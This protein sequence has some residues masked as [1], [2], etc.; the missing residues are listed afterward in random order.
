VSTAV[1][2]NL[3][4]G[5]LGA[6]KTTLIRRLLAASPADERWAVLV[7]EMGQV[8]ID[9]ALFSGSGGTVRELPGGCL[10]CTLGVPF[11]VAIVDLLRRVR[12]DRLIIEPT[13]I[14]HP[15]EIVDR[16]RDPELGAALRLQTILTVIDPRRLS[17]QRVLDLGVFRDQVTLADGLVASHGDACSAEDWRR[18]QELAEDCYPPKDRVADARDADPAWLSEPGGDGR[19]LISDPD[20]HH[21]DLPAQ[22]EAAG[23]PARGRPVRYATA[24]STAVAC[25]WVWL[26]GDCFDYDVLLDQLTAL[27]GAQRLKG[28]FRTD[29]GWYAI[30]QDGLSLS[31][32]RSVWR[33]D[34]RLEIIAEMAQDWDAVE[35]RLAG[36]LLSD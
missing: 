34:S 15:A 1:P 23:E 25:G 7:N 28:V 11:R 27:S 26:A 5:L 4:T 30:Q 31:V 10:C 6:G 24:S 13:G 35:R 14:G 33:R 32:E 21:H 2:T 12:P 8:G 29:Q 19:A 36:A 20:G 17:E 16:L 22:N 18:F 3:V 9:E